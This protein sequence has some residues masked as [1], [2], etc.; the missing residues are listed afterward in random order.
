MGFRILGETPVHE[1]RCVH[2]GDGRRHIVFV[3]LFKSESNFAAR[4]YGPKKKPVDVRFSSASIFVVGGVAGIS[5]RLPSQRSI[6]AG[7]RR[8]RASKPY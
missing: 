3:Q 4:L 1:L 8:W 5:P 6:P 2:R 7:H